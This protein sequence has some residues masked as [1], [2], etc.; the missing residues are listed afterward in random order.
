MN[1]K[2]YSLIV[3]LL[4]TLAGGWAAGCHDDHRIID[5]HEQALEDD[6]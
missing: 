1:L 4:L 3:S 2:R 6:E 5:K